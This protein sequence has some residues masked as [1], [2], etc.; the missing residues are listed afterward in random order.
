MRIGGRVV[1][2]AQTAYL[3]LGLTLTSAVV[4]IFG[5]VVLAGSLIAFGGATEDVSQHNGVA[6]SDPAHLRFFI[7]HRSH[8]VDQAA[9]ILTSVGMV[10]VVLFIAVGAAALFW[11]RGLRVGLAIAPVLSFAGAAAAVSIVKALIGRTRP[12]VSLHLVA[13]SD[14]SF[15]SGHATNSAAVFVTIGVI[16]ALYLLR[17]P[18]AR[19]AAPI[20]A[21]LLSG[22]VGIS[23]LVL[24]VHW[25]SDVAAGWALGL[26]IALAVTITLSLFSRLVQSSRNDADGLLSR[27]M[28]RT[29]EVLAIQRRT[30]GRALEAA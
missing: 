21:V 16:A 30:P 23:R 8:T 29:G 6:L 18:I 10:A 1:R 20:I 7:D 14:A 11:Y 17:R 12:P 3:A 24:G 27:T 19:A 26:A 13:E 9:R 4:L 22:L 2:A 25:P 28:N 15:P 5:L